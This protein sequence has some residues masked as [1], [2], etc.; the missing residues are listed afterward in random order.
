MRVIS[1]TLHSV[2]AALEVVLGLNFNL[3][4]GGPTEV[5]F[6]LLKLVLV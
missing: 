1:D 6:S 3:W 2:L 5:G 4:L